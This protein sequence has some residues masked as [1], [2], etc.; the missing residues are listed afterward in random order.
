M[1]SFAT[2][3]V[4][5]FCSLDVRTVWP[6]FAHVRVPLCML[7]RGVQTLCIGPDFDVHVVV[8]P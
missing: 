4:L 3:R 2:D 6:W 7:T 5:N 1:D 8:F